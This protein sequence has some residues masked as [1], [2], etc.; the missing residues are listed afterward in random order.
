MSSTVLILAG[1]DESPTC[2]VRELLQVLV[3]RTYRDQAKQLL[4]RPVALKLCGEQFAGT[5]TSPVS[6]APPRT[7]YMPPRALPRTSTPHPLPNSTCLLRPRRYPR[8]SVLLPRA[9]EHSTQSLFCPVVSPLSRFPSPARCHTPLGALSCP[10]LFVS[11]IHCLSFLSG[12]GSSSQAGLRL[13]S[14]FPLPLPPFPSSPLPIH[15]H[16]AHSTTSR[17]R[18]P[19]R[20][21]TLRRP[22]VNALCRDSVFHD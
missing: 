1:G 20:L 5:C 17:R 10:V 9:L 13:I 4:L 14:F 8:R 15:R 3:L 19:L 21:S 22:R 12:S 6:P 11:P 16:P 2:T 7:C 18:F